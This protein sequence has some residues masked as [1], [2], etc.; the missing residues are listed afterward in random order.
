V[1]DHEVADADRADLAVGEQRLERPVG[2]ERP[3]E[4]ARQGLVEDQQVD[5]VDAELRRALL[6]SVQRRLVPVV[7]DPDLGLEEDVGA[8][9][10]GRT[11]RLADLALVA[12]GGGGVDVAV[13]GVERGSDRVAGLVGRRLKD[14]QAEGGQFDAVVECEGGDGDYGVRPAGR[15]PV[16]LG[17]PA[18]ISR[19]SAASCFSRRCTSA[20]SSA[21]SAGVF[22]RGRL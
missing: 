8:V 18:A 15:L 13:A 3:V 22:A 5:L 4:R 6:V 19:R 7:G 11:D 16:G 1:V 10:P 12:V 20:A 17:L 14:A 21:R 2:L 9:E